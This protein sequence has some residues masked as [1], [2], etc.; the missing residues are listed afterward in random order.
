MQQKWKPLVAESEVPKRSYL[1]PLN[2]I[3]Y[4][5]INISRKLCR[6]REWEQRCCDGVIGLRRSE[7]S[8]RAPL[9]RKRFL[10]EVG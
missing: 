7:I 5:I 3:Q 4:D 6:D 2:L 1:V 8:S 10:Q 9:R